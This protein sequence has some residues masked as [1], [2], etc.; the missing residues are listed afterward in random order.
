M[1]QRS[2]STLQRRGEGSK[3][4]VRRRRRRRRQWPGS[5]CPGRAGCLAPNDGAPKASWEAGWQAGLC[6][7]V[8]HCAPEVGA[9]LLR[10]QPAGVACRR[11]ARRHR[12][13][14]LAGQ[15]QEAGSEAVGGLLQLGPRRQRGASGRQ[16]SQQLHHQRRLL[17]LSIPG[18][19]APA[20]AEVVA[21]V[22][23]WQGRKGGR[24][25]AGKGCR[26]HQAAAQRSLAGGRLGRTPKTQACCGPGDQATRGG[27]TGTGTHSITA[28]QGGRAA[29]PAGWLG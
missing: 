25:S 3:E 18:L 8:P 26:M 28:E 5:S 15:A 7:A 22:V 10:G 1:A 29:M 2:D 12:A 11:Q 17:Q 20:G 24:A 21:A 9:V 13:G 14:R 23:G 4:A 6:A 27:R 19:P 16:L